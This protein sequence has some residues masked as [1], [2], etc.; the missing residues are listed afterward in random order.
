MDGKNRHGKPKIAIRDQAKNVDGQV[1]NDLCRD[2]GISKR[3][4]SPYHPEGDGQTGRSVQAIKMLLRTHVQDRAMPKYYWPSILQE[5]VF[6][7]NAAVNASTAFAPYEIM[8]GSKPR[9]LPQRCTPDGFKIGD[10]VPIEEKI[11]EIRN[12]IERIWI[13]AASK[14]QIS[15]EAYK[16]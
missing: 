14:L 12:K 2:L 10:E 6:S 15:K 11:E 8:Y 3:R 7:Q 16:A 1:A 4:S 13:E 5:A 9:L